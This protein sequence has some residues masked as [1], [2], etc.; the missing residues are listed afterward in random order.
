MHIGNPVMP[1]YRQTGYLRGNKDRDDM[2]AA[3]GKARA[4]VWARCLS[5]RV[6]TG[7]ITSGLPGI[8]LR[9]FARCGCRHAHL[10]G[11]GA[12]AHHRVRRS[13]VHRCGFHARLHVHGR[14]RRGDRGKGQRQ[15]DQDR[16]DGAQTVQGQVSFQS[17]QTIMKLL[18]FPSRYIQLM[19]RAPTPGSRNAW[20]SK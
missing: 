1:L 10:H 12:I 11:P 16:E 3:F 8:T 17:G 19:G 14:L 6:T 2:R 9:G 13:A 18:N 4:H 5:L 15:C 20:K 7:A